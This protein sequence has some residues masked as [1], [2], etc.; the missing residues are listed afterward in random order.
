MTPLIN[1]VPDK[2]QIYSEFIFCCP[3]NVWFINP[4]VLLLPMSMHRH[5]Q[6]NTMKASPFLNMITVPKIF[7]T[8]IFLTYKIHSFQLKASRTDFYHFNSKVVSC[9]WY[10]G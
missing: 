2:D 6:R 5:I 3:V 4:S 8:D 9:Q 7:Q 10:Q 1:V